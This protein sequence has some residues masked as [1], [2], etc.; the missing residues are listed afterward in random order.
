M[1]L[2]DLNGKYSKS[3]YGNFEEQC[4][5]YVNISIRTVHNTCSSMY[6]LCTVYAGAI[7]VIEQCC[8]ASD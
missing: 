4:T 3:F 1:T 2:N 7:R 5:E 8:P 6:V